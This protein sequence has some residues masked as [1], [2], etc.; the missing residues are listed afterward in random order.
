MVVNLNE[1]TMREGIYYEY[2][3][4]NKNNIVNLYNIIKHVLQLDTCVCIA[5][6][7]CCPLETITKL[8]TNDTPMQN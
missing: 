4:N 8:L 5:E 1:N 3:F 7:L 6:P 2:I